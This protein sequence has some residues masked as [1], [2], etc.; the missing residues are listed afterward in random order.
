MMRRNLALGASI[1]AL[2]FVVFR[3][4]LHAP[5]SD[6]AER[7]RDG[8]ERYEIE[9]KE[10][11]ESKEYPNDWFYIQRAYPGTGI[12]VEA[13]LKAAADARKM[14]A[15]AAVK[16]SRSVSWI[17]AGPTNIPGRITDLAVHPSQPQV[18]YA[19]SA[20]GGVYKSVD[21]G[22]TWTAVFDSTGVQSVG[23]IAI[24]PDNP[25]ILYVG[26]GEAN[27]ATDS[28]E[29]TGVYKSVDAG[30]T[31]TH[32]GLPNSYHIG[33]VLIDPLRP[34]TVYVA[35]MGKL[36]GTTN[37]ERGLYRSQDGGSNWELLLYSNDS[38][39]CIDVAIHPSTGTLFAAMWER[40][41]DPR[42]R[43]VGGLSSGLYRSTDWGDTWTL[44]PGLP[45]PD[46]ILG[47]IGVTVDPESETVYAFLVNDPGWVIGVYRSL[48]LGNTW[49]KTQNLFGLALGF[50]WYFGQIR[51]APGN[52]GICYVLAIGMMKT[53]DS[54]A[55]YSPADAGTHVDHHALYIDPVTPDILY[56]GSDGG[57][58]YSTDGGESWVT[59]GGMANTQF[60][61][62]T[63]DEQNP[64][65]LYGGTQDNGTMRTL[66][67]LTDDWDGI[68]GG[69]G[70]YTVVDYAD[71]AI[72]YAEA[73]WGGLY[74]SPN[75]GIYFNRALNG[76]DYS[77]E[78]HNWCT[79]FVMDPINSNVLYYGSNR[80]Y[81][82]LDGAEN[83]SAISGD[84]TNGPDSGNLTFGTIT[85]IDVARRDSRVIY[86]GTDDANVW[87]TTDGGGNWNNIS[88]DL[89]DRWVTRVA[90]DP[91]A[92]GTA[93]VTFSGFKEG[94]NLPHIFR[95]TDFGQTWGNLHGNL[96]DAPINDVII[97]PHDDSTL[98]IATDF[99]VF[100][101]ADLGQT[102]EPLGTGMPIVPVNDL[103]FHTR[104]R[105]LVAG[106]HGRSMY[107][108]A[109]PCPDVVDSDADG[110]ADACD[111]CPDDHNTDQAD[112]D[113]DGIGN[114][115]DCDCNYQ[116]DFDE[117]GYI[118]A[119]DLARLIDVLFAGAPDL[120]DPFCPVPRGD[121]DCDGFTTA[122]DL[123]LKIDHIFAGGRG[124]CAP[125]P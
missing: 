78:R 12:P 23:A 94:S 83:W 125:C 32:V 77:N 82:T 74:K 92:P 69:D 95:T 15:D 31:W 123:A 75:G 11:G 26:T 9:E 38:T 48:D 70:F 62:I 76:M 86:V 100:T 53:T 18:I 56:D 47:R 119:I 65:R 7:E 51:V 58:S 59:F 88:A 61:A 99:G 40:W 3:F 37:P 45:Q 104:T 41:R 80:L 14:Y 105:T 79:P 13:R 5:V 55:H 71:P 25:N 8:E 85:T 35:A 72:I 118:T 112:T 39:G 93:I 30:A 24:H 21:F 4:G 36:F 87:V 42:E 120:R 60:Y 122:M 2:L 96:P 63:I 102:W 6:L 68:F 91:Y 106:T 108:T 20:A 121:D 27:T 73:Q 84:L 124:P 52:P 28:Y 34:E 116:N 114:V 1:L 113:R 110:Y 109:I 111:N 107:R 64:E 16:S 97:D 17:E 66:T 54:G 81:K 10:E 117:D 29:G 44:L 33:R 115:C 98:Y 101:T 22:A 89:P 67:G 50:G 90:A 49:V 19:A 46:T 103:V 43:H 57:V